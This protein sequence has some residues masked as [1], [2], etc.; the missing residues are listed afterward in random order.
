[1]ATNACSSG[2]VKVEGKSIK[3]SY[4]VEEG[5]SISF[6]KNKLDHIYKV[7]KVIEKRV[8]AELAQKCYEDLSPPPPESHELMSAFHQAAARAKGDGRPTK[9]DRRSID[10]F[11][12]D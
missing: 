8:G 10:K 6:K 7:L 11:K 2:K 12:G 9:R 3:A 1:M 4:Q 5:T